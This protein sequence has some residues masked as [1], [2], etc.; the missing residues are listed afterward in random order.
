MQII[1]GTIESVVYKNN[2]GHE[3]KL[4]SLKCMEQQ[5]AFVEFRG[6]QMMKELDSFIEDDQI[7][8]AVYFEGKISR[9]TGIHFNNLVAKSVRKA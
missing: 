3:K 2:L 9:T 4:V 5:R 1:T 6:K 7:Q 8:V